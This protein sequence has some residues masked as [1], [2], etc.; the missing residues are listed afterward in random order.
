MS[1]KRSRSALGGSP[2]A[3]SETAIG[4]NVHGNVQ[5][6]KASQ[7]RAL[8]KLGERRLKADVPLTP[9]L[10]SQLAE[11][12]DETRR[13]VG[14]LIDRRGRVESVVVG[15]AR[16]LYLPDLG[17]AR[18]GG[19]RFRGLRLIRTR[20]GGGDL[21]SHDDLTDLSKLNL[22][23]VVAI[24]VEQDGSAGRVG[25]AHLIPDNPAR[26]HWRTHEAP[27]ASALDWSFDDF[28]RDL[29]GEFESK[30]EVGRQTQ[31]DRAVI[32]YV[33]TRSDY[34][35]AQNLAELRELC[36]TAGVVV[37]EAY[38][39]SRAELD[40][41]TAVGKG[42]LEEIELRCLQ[43]GADIAIFGQDL[44]PA[45]MKN[46]T[47]QTQLRV[48]DRTQLILDIFAQRAQSGVGKLQVELAQLKYQ[49]PRLVGRG[50]GMS[51]LAGGI[52]GRG[53]GE[54]R[55]EM[56]RR[57]AR[58][59]IHL[60][61]QGIEKLRADRTLRRK[62]RLDSAVPTVAIVGYTN[63][64]KSTLLNTLT[65]AR[66]L[67]EDKL[68]ATLD[69]TTRRLRS[70]QERELI[71]T[72]TVGFIRDLPAELKEAFRATLEEL[73]AADL[74]LHVVDASDPAF[75]AQMRSTQTLLE[76]LG[77]TERPRL[78]VFNKVDALSSDQRVDLGLAYPDA[79]Q[80][81]AL[82]RESARP[83]LEALDRW[84]VRSGHGEVVPEWAGA[85]ADDDG[86]T[87]GD[88]LEAEVRDPT[89]DPEASA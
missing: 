7:R 81:S 54:S 70:P 9:E 30:R 83:L 28:V 37:E 68:F 47:S 23:L 56:D 77:H 11:L 52:G 75:E 61:E 36:R 45:Q 3:L 63:A 16:R 50:T 69:P 33:R 29:E 10:A 12:S 39:Q 67:A 79:V 4:T 14:V 82:Q 31:T 6:L 58:D 13:A 26:E 64:G 76:E 35:H 62:N 74:L 51:R 84:L 20:L 65:H 17:R 5:S 85:A 71:L 41:K 66:V 44:S 32:V 21:L 86:G 80:V 57:R 38:V 88:G 53:P 15:D 34:A 59:R 25:W 27:R 72:D 42:A 2:P 22:D 49:L 1:G 8:E 46:I 78:L 48:I 19:S 89:D 24:A 40:P 43:L 55:L 73:E 87:D 18:A 60:L